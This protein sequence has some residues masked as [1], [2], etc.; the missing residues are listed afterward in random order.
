[1][2]RR[3]ASGSFLADG[4]QV[5]QAVAVEIR[6]SN[7]AGAGR[8]PVVRD[9]W[10]FDLLEQLAAPGGV[11]LG[12]AGGSGAQCRLRTGQVGRWTAGILGIAAAAGD[13]HPQQ[14][15]AGES[16]SEPFHLLLRGLSALV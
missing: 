5:D 9:A 16:R 11:A 14:K 12:V 7:T 4:K 8:N 6:R 3:S 15:R 10:Q 13:E 1:M 2:R